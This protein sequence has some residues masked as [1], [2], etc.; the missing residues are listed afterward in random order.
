MHYVRQLPGIEIPTLALLHA[1]GIETVADLAL[2][3]P[4]AL[5]GHARERRDLTLD[6]ALR[7]KLG[8]AIDAA[9]EALSGAPPKPA[10][11]LAGPPKDRPLPPQ[12][13]TFLYMPFMHAES[14]LVHESVQPLLEALGG[15]FLKSAEG[16]L[17]VLRRFGRYPK[18]NAA[19]GRA[20]TPEELAYIAEGG[21]RMF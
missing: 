5:W 20:S 1:L 17:D 8:A 2:W 11:L 7:L 10:A 3:E 12:R 6:P 4:H 16:H 14:L 18:R 19:L 21:D 15:D 13:R 9:R